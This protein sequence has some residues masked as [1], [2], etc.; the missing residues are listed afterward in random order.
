MTIAQDALALLKADHQ[1][2]DALFGRF[3]ERCN[4]AADDAEKA[5][6]VEKIRLLLTIHA[7]IEDEVFYPAIRMVLGSDELIDEALADHAVADQLLR[8]LAI[9]RP[10]GPFYRAKVTVLAE[11]VRT[12]VSHEEREIFPLARMSGIDLFDLAKQIDARKTELIDRHR[13]ARLSRGSKAG[14]GND[15]AEPVIK[16]LMHI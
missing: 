2:I 6:I 13:S 7:R 12:H 8:Q 9:M 16:L 3:H 14:M 15:T 1:E 11:N 10:A 5:A 4:L